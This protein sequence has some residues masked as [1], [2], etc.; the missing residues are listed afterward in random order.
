MACGTVLLKSHVVYI[1]IL[2]FRPKKLDYRVPI[3]SC[4]CLTSRIFEEEW[5][6]ASSLKSLVHFLTPNA[7]ILW[8]NQSIKMK[9]RLIAEGDFVRKISIQLLFH[10]PLNEIYSLSVVSRLLY[11][12]ELCKHE[13]ANLLEMSNS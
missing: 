12:I 8:I 7:T 6:E 5:S 10:N 4:Y 1:C 11:S 2:Q 3:A 13:A 9:M